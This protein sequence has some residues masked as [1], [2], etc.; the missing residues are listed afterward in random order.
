MCDQLAISWEHFPP[1]CFFPEEKD[2]KDIGGQILKNLRTNLDQ[3]SVPS[4]PLHNMTTSKDDEY[5][6][7]ILFSH[8]ENNLQLQ[9]VILKKIMRAINRSP[10]IR[11]FYTNNPKMVMV[12]GQP[13]VT[14]TVDF[15]R[16]RKELDKIARAAYYK[17]FGEKWIKDIEVYS[18]GIL[19]DSEGKSKASA[20]YNGGVLYMS[21]SS[22]K[23]M[24][25]YP[26]I[27]AHPEVFYHQIYREPAQNFLF[28]R[29]VFY[30]GL[31]IM[32]M[33]KPDNLSESVEQSITS[34][35]EDLFTN[36]N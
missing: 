5:L 24:K 32:A 11:S 14:I 25:Y 28:I 22:E 4:C 31:V 3:Q 10:A 8:I 1:K 33:S 9:T 18:P 7:A 29:M 23:L 36:S 20:I 16:I 19:P 27:G 34:T 15:S 13:G 2:L 35:A 17:D 21:K 26:K 30:E 6:L 12:N